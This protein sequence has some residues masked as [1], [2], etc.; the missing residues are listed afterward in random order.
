MNFFTHR[1]R[2]V[3]ISLL[4]SFA[5]VLVFNLHGGS[6][7]KEIYRTINTQA[8]KTVT[9]QA[10]YNALALFK[11][12]EALSSQLKRPEFTVYTTDFLNLVSSKDEPELRKD[13]N[14]RIDKLYMDPEFVDKLYI[15]GADSSQKSFVSNIGSKAV[16]DENPPSIEDLEYAGLLDI[17]TNN[18]TGIPLYF[19]QGELIA[20]IYKKWNSATDQQIKRVT[21]FARQLEG[22]LLLTNRVNFSLELLVLSSDMFERLIPEKQFPDVVLSVSTQEGKLIWHN[23]N[24]SAVRADWLEYVKLLSPYGLK[25]TIAFHYNQHAIFSILRTYAAV[26]LV[27]IVASLMLS[28]WISG[29]IV[30]P[31]VEL[32]KFMQL[33]GGKLPLNIVPENWAGKQWLPH[34]SVRL[35]VL[36]LFMLSVGLPIIFAIIFYW[37]LL[38][39]FSNHQLQS[40][41]ERITDQTG[42]TVSNE[43]QRYERMVQQLSENADLLSRMNR[44]TDVLSGGTAPS[45]DGQYDYTTL[46][47][48]SYFVLFDSLGRVNYSSIFSDSPAL[49]HLEPSVFSNDPDQDLLWQPQGPDIF[50]KDTLKIVG[51]LYKSGQK[52]SER[53]GYIQIV[54]KPDVFQSIPL[55]ASVNWKLYTNLDQLLYDVFSTKSELLN[56]LRNYTSVNRSI[57]GTDRKLVLQYPKDLSNDLRNRLLLTDLVVLLTVFAVCMLAGQGM[58]HIIVRTIRKM[59]IRMDQMSDNYLQ[60]KFQYR[61]NDEL[62]VLVQSFNEMI[63]KINLLMRENIESRTR[64]QTMLM[65]KSQAELNMLQQ[66]INPHFLYNTLESINMEAQASESPKISTMVSAL[67]QIFRYS[68]SKGPELVPLSTEIKHT[69]NYIAIQ[70]IRFRDRFS[71]EY[72]ISEEVLSQPVLKFILQPIVENAIQH[73]LSEYTSGGELHISAKCENGCIQIRVADNGVGMKKNQIQEIH[74]RMQVMDFQAA[75]D[76]VPTSRSGYGMDNVFRRLQLYYGGKAEFRIES[77]LMKGTTIVLIIPFHMDMKN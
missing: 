14:N 67:A 61:S 37:Q 13:L 27:V 23:Q 77:K 32:S 45:V 40:S 8:Q 42:L 26:S 48:L 53:T 2:I 35:K 33:E 76:K 66:Q 60:P 52:N 41:M 7:A 69:Q 22:K 28:I 3:G 51:N 31:I 57:A 68:I 19:N 46:G 9:E 12:L 24:E 4:L 29:K 71:V 58:S 11:E 47:D 65:L 39:T 25:M 16:L 17:F 6:Q 75:D 43:M 5:A 63:Y 15:L 74:E 62:G 18:G 10:E 34:L 54:L 38:N 44:S 30:S 59:Q 21:A 1:I 72:Q 20:K 50:R 64:E 36:Y 73:G 55:P 70:Q 49:F 56:E